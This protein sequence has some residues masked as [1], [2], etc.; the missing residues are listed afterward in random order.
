MSTDFE[1]LS[2]LIANETVDIKEIQDKLQSTNAIKNLAEFTPFEVKLTETSTLTSTVAILSITT[3]LIIAIVTIVIINTLCPSVLPFCFKLILKSISDLCCSCLERLNC[4]KTAISARQ[5]RPSEVPL[6]RSETL[7]NIN[8][9][10]PPIENSNL[11][12]DIYNPMHRV[13]FSIQDESVE[14]DNFYQIPHTSKKPY[15]DVL[16]QIASASIQSNIEELPKI[17]KSS[18]QQQLEQEP[19]W[20]IVKSKHRVR[21]SIRVNDDIYYYDTFSQ[22]S[23]DKNEIVNNMLDPPTPLMLAKLQQEIDKLSPPPMTYYNNVL[24]VDFDHDLFY[25]EKRKQF[26][27]QRLNK[28]IDGYNVPSEILKKI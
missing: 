7:Q 11:E 18:S 9:S 19:Q 25:D 23:Y 27:S 20:I 6:Q 2:K 26:F 3:V 15:S 28:P 24:H 4:C 8:V 10:A 21:L 12:Q 13:H 16:N 5:R 17:I 14:L 22:K 1:K